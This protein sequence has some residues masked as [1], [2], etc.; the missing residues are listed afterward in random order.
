[1]NRLVH[2]VTDNIKTNKNQSKDA[3]ENEPKVDKRF[4]LSIRTK[5]RL[6]VVTVTLQGG[7][8]QRATSVSGITCLCDSGVTGSMI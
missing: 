2:V 4:S 3:I 7:K 8:K 1:M 6:P 5:Y